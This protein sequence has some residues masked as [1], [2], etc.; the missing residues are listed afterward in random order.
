MK[1]IIFLLLI[2]YYALTI[3]NCICQWIQKSNGMGNTNTI[4]ALLS[5]G[6][7]ILAGASGFP[8]Y[9]IS[10]NSGETWVSGSNTLYASVESFASIGSNIFAGTNGGIFKSSDNGNNWSQIS[11]IGAYT[12]EVSGS[13]LYAGTSNGVYLS[14]NNGNNWIALNNGLFMEIRSLTVS[15]NN[16]FAGTIGSGVYVSHNN[17]TNWTYSGLSP[18]NIWALTISGSNVVA[19]CGGSSGGGIYYSINNGANWIVSSIPGDEGHSFI[20]YNNNLFVG[21]WSNGISRSNNYGVNWTDVSQGFPSNAPI[22]TQLIANNFIFVGTDSKSVWRRPLS[23]VIG[24][25]NINS[26]I[27]TKYSISQNYPNPFNPTTNIKFTIPSNVKSQTSNVKLVVFD[28][29]GKEVVALVN[30]KLEV[31]T[32]EV[33]WDASQYPSGVY[34]YRL[35]TESFSETKKMILLK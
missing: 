12:L 2:A 17:G 29:L 13:N 14:T 11:S 22:Y 15:G 5:V 27:P 8:A 16:I 18:K 24:I 35:N 26:E 3:E 28:I 4:K 25:K 33:S 31:G 20:K 1:K 23:E 30:E 9:Y 7:N 34:F 10:T 32:Y 19:G 21:R 6:T